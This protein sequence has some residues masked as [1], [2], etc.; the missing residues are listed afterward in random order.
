MKSF[1]R[2]ILLIISSIVLFIS[3]STERKLAVYYAKNASSI[4]ALV[5]SPAFLYK[6][7]QKT[8]LLDSLGITDESIFDSVLY[9]NSDLLQYVNDSLFLS[10]YIYGL[11]KELAVFGIKVYGE[12]EMGSF[13]ENDSNAVLINVAQVELEEVLYP[14]EDITQIYD[15]KYTYSHLLNAVYINSWIE[16][17]KYDQVNSTQQVYFASDLI[18]D[19]VDG[20]FNYDVFS[21]KIQYMYNYDSLTVS[22]IYD[23][24]YVLGRTYAGYTFDLL[25]NTYLDKK[26]L[27]GSRSD[28]YWRYDPIKHVFFPA[29]KDMFILME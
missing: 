6:V 16:I 12:K 22:Q 8:Y 25:L 14:W 5:L 1:F 18:T 3:C 2:Q 15:T 4:N 27:N 21:Q 23:Y 19:I 13:L 26:L 29:Q 20:E 28:K 11:K 24:A 10:N 9:A 17:G 7:N